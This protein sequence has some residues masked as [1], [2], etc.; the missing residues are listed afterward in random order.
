MKK[1]TDSL[2]NTNLLFCGIGGQGVLKASEIA[3]EAALLSG[4]HVKKSEVHG[5]SQ[6]GGSVDSHVRYGKTVYSPLITPG[7]ADILIPFA[8]EEGVPLRKFLKKGG[9]DLTNWLEIANGKIPDKKFLNTYMLGIL[10][11]KLALPQRHWIS[12]LSRIFT[13]SID[14]N[15]T[16]FLSAWEEAERA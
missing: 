3:A 9:L 11:A 6:R 7:R 2:P 15:R 8:A 4:F 10:A 14:E 16:V 12:A 1:N 5:M 13:R